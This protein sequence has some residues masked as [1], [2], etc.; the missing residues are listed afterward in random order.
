MLA[1]DGRDGDGASARRRVG[2]TPA[3]Y[4]CPMR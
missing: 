1:P 3:S 2:A 4:R